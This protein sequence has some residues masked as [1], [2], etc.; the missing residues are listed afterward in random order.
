MPLD[1]LG[2]RNP[3]LKIRVWQRIHI[4]LLMTV[5][6]SHSAYLPPHMMQSPA[7]VSPAIQEPLASLPTP[8]QPT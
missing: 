3:G 2:F 1:I 5:H 4:V 6:E 8:Y 7:A